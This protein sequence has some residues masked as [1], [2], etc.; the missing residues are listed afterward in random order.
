MVKAI[1]A[2]DLTLELAYTLYR[3]NGDA[4]HDVACAVG[5]LDGMLEH[6]TCHI[7]ASEMTQIADSVTQHSETHRS[8]TELRSMYAVE[9]G[10]ARVD[11]SAT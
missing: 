6:L 1:R 10:D 2:I 8:L 9:R 7:M 4:S 5:Y 11:G 3:I